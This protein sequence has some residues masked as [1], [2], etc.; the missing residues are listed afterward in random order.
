MAKALTKNGR[1]KRR[2]VEELERDLELFKKFKA[3]QTKDS[4]DGK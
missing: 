3:Q 2:L 1:T 4:G